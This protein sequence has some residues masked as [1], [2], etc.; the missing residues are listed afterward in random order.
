[1]QSYFEHKVLQTAAQEAMVAD[2]ASVAKEALQ[3]L[4]GLLS[5]TSA[6]YT[7]YALTDMQR[8]LQLEKQW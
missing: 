7:C 5:K 3:Q 6:V 8:R 2:Q 1:M 4:H